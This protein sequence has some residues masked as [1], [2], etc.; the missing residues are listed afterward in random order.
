M[1]FIKQIDGYEVWLASYDHF[2]EWKA[3]IILS[4][5]NAAVVDLRFVDNPAAY[6]SYQSVQAAGISLIYEKA[7]RFPLYVDIL[8]HEKPLHV[9]LYENVTGNFAKCLLGT[10]REPIGEDE[11]SARGYVPMKEAAKKAKKVKK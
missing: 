1:P 11:L 2:N 4:Y 5:S 3:N 7:E 10:S 6:A 8:R 9:V